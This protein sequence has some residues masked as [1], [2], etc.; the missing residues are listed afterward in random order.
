MKDGGHASGKPG[1]VQAAQLGEVTLAVQ[2]LNRMTRTAM[3][4]SVRR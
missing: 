4:V 2:V 1:A 3:P